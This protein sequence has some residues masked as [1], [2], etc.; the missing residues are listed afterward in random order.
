MYIE[1]KGLYNM[2][3]HT[4][5]YYEEPITNYKLDWE[6]F[7]AVVNGMVDWNKARVYKEYWENDV[8]LLTLSN[9]TGR[10]VAEIKGIVYDRA[11]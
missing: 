2:L 3:A 7:D 4:K 8:S 9:V 1:I 10:T 6:R 5:A 11:S